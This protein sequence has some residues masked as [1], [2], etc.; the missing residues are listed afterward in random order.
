M[1]A[2]RCRAKSRRCWSRS[3]AAITAAITASM[4]AAAAGASAT[5]L[6]MSPCSRPA[7]PKSTS[8]LSVKCRKKVRSVSPARS[9]ISATVVFSNPRSP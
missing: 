5:A 7:P 2:C 1:T 8:R 6:T 9:A 3:P 4:G